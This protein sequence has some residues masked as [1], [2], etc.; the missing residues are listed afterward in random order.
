[1]LQ[2]R[3]RTA[4]DGGDFGWLKAKHH[5]IVSDKGNPA[6]Q[7]LGALVVWNDDEI[8]PGRGFPLH[9]HADMEIIS[10]VRQ[11]A[12]SHR[13]STGS[14]GETAAGDVQVMSAG[15][16]IRHEEHNIGSIALKL[17]QIWIRP[18]ERGGPPRWDTRPFPKEDRAGRLVPLASGL[19]GDE[20]AL[21]IRADARVLGATLKA[22]QRVNHQLDIASHAYLVPARGTVTVNGKRVGTGDGVAITQET[23]ITIQAVEDAEFV[24]VEAL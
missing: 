8:A 13:D 23:D 15:T 11:G 14:Y 5:F 12:V 16:G 6:H 2:H 1:M 22:G 7:A 17:F 9:G 3:P 24:L 10:Y 20:E 21:L 4:L 19:P 18:R